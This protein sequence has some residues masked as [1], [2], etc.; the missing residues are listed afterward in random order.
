MKKEKKESK[1][2]VAKGSLEINEFIKVPGR[3]SISTILL[4]RFKGHLIFC[5]LGYMIFTYTL[6]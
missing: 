1:K 4:A 3:F 5:N 6:V 2:N